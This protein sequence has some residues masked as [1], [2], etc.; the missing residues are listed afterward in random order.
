MFVLQSIP[1]L[2]RTEGGNPRAECS[3]S[4]SQD[5]V[6]EQIGVLQEQD[7]LLTRYLVD[8]VKSRSLDDVAALKRNKAEVRSE[9]S[10]LQHSMR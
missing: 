7:R 9:I 4:T 5:S 3:S 1:T 8:A 10:R 2:H 6:A